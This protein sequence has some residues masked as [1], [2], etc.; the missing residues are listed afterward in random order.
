LIVDAAVELAAH[1]HNVHV[2]TAHHD[3]NRCFE[4]TVTGENLMDL[5]TWK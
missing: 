4:E 3:R 2:F 1:G 5:I